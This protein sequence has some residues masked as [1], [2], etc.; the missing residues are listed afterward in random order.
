MTKE[1]FV[2]YAKYN[3]QGNRA[4]YDILSKMANDD[5]EKERGSYYG[6]L[7][8]LVRHIF[9]GTYF[10]LGMFRPALAKNAAASK[11]LDA[12]GGIAKLPEGK[13]TEAQWKDVG[14]AL[15]AADAAY[16]AVCEALG[17]ADITSPLKIDWYGGNPAEV[18]LCFMLHQLIVHNTHHR[19][20]VS[21]ILDELKIDNDYSG[22][23]VAFLPK[24]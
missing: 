21:Q 23:D 22:I 6:S 4:I 12:L 20:Q 3:K 9:G 17:E 11:A 2:M 13:L 24:C 10:F 14:R 15:D 1:L 8:G 5:R 7:S 16:L 18:P 19:G